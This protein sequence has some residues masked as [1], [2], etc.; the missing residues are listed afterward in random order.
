MEKIKTDNE[1][2]AL[3]KGE[4]II[5]IDFNAH[6]SNNVDVAKVTMAQLINEINEIPSILDDMHVKL[7]ADQLID[8][9]RLKDAESRRNRL[10]AMAITKLE[11]AS[12]LITK[13]YTEDY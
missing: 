9:G 6:R 1:Y 13:V 5:R 8:E 10:K 7:P 12:M 4:K 11:E 3:S 2:Y